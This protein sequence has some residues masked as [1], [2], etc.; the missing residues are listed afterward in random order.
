[1]FYDE[2]D[3]PIVV[4]NSSLPPPICTTIDGIIQ[5]LDE[6][7]T[8]PLTLPPLSLPIPTTATI[9]DVVHALDKS[10]TGDLQLSP[11]VL[12][13]IATQHTQMPYVNAIVSVQQQG[14]TGRQAVAVFDKFD[15]RIMKFPLQ[16]MHEHIYDITTSISTT[17][18]TER[19]KGF[20]VKHNDKLL[21][22]LFEMDA[23]PPMIV[24][25][26]V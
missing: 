19:K 20:R 13:S 21:D 1:M 6:S 7:C 8:G 23:I 18:K 17:K 5:S 25:Y 10:C 11:I 4:H 2:S 26:L 16:Y 24:P 12:D 3:S 9:D 22:K 15:D 14:E